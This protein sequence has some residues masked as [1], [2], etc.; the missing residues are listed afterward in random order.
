MK[1]LIEIL[2]LGKYSCVIRSGHEIHTFSRRGVADLYD[3]VKNK[4]GLL[5]GASVADKVVGKGA[6]ALMI[7]GGI[8][9]LYTDVISQSALTLLQGTDINTNF[10]RVVPFIQNRDKSG[11]CP[12]EKMCDHESSAEAIGLLIEEFINT[13][14]K[15]QTPE[16][17]PEVI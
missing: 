10:G 12:V 16:P 9:E 17:A 7:L 8:K 2:H 6:A 1:E 4:P 13:R 11:W 3:L 15:L 5:Q 14:K